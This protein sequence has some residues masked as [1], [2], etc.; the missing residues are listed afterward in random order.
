MLCSNWDAM[1]LTV[2]VV[3][4]FEVRICKNLAHAGEDIAM[5]KIELYVQ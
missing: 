5:E 1:V 3:D 2:P 4:D